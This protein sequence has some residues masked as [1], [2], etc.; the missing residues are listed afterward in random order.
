MKK[1]LLMCVALSAAVVV[2]AQS[3]RMKSTATPYK[4]KSVVSE[5]APS[6]TTSS[7]TR[8]GNGNQ[9]ATAYQMGAEPN[10]YG[11]AGTRTILWYNPEVDVLAFIHRSL[12]DPNATPPTSSGFL[13]VDVSYDRGQNWST[14]QGPIYIDPT[15][16]VGTGAQTERARYPQCVIYN[17]LG[18]TDVN[19]AKIGY[20]AAVTDGTGW[21]EQVYGSSNLDGS[22]AQQGAKIFDALYQADVPQDMAYVKN[23]G[24]V[25]IMDRKFDQTGV[26]YLN[27]LYAIHGV[28]DSGTGTYNYTATELPAA[29]VG[30]TEVDHKI[31]F[32][33]DGTIGYISQMGNQCVL[34]QQN[35]GTIATDSTIYF[36]VWKT[37]DGGATWGAPT[38]VYVQGA[39]ASLMD[40]A[41]LSSGFE[42]DLVIDANNNL[43]ICTTIGVA[44]STTS[45]IRNAP[46]FYGIF[47][48]NT[49][50]GGTTW[51]CTEVARPQS[52][53]GDFGSGANTLSEDNR[54]QASRSWDGTKLFFS[55]C[56]TDTVTWAT[57]DNIFPDMHVVGFDLT[58]GLWS[59]EVTTEGGDADGSVFQG[60]ASYYV[61]DNN[62]GTYTVPCV[63]GFAS[64]TG[65][66]IDPFD[67]YYADDLVVGNFTNSKDVFPLVSDNCIA[68]A[69]NNITHLDFS[70]SSNYPNPFDATTSFDVTLE[71]N[72]T[73][74]IEITDMIG[75]VVLTADYG[76]M[77]SGN[78]TINLDASSLS[79]GMY[80][81][82]VKVNSNVVSGKMNVK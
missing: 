43:H 54:P 48:I 73:V 63:Y 72:S 80:V 50:D 26:V 76:K 81:Y 2:S 61:I 29:T 75:K 35:G 59:A 31:A 15:Y 4:K 3:A 71:K 82:N 58:T 30:G 46:G 49:T 21:W 70:V 9:Q 78:H 22:N 42:H 14:N 32:N 38:N 11:T 53:R 16:D 52:F 60:N 10:A 13:Q 69:T 25:W 44:G 56:E 34:N 37:T 79:T 55:W 57:P 20:Y 74:S 40:S 5:A 66:V 47:D 19:N 18:N 12:I 6:Q 33:D 24:D 39:D 62:N 45:E 7:T 77:N 68:L 17:P 64:V 41:T 51:A 1:S 23:T 8:N 67:F 28:W 36:I 65:S 27:G